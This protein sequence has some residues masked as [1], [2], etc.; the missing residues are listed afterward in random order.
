M[1]KAF[2]LES[3]KILSLSKGK[4]KKLDFDPEFIVQGVSFL[5]GGNVCLG[6]NSV[7]S[8]LD[9]CYNVYCDYRLP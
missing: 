5:V 9:G 3:L 7:V 1:N 8:T 2:S 4:E 6:W